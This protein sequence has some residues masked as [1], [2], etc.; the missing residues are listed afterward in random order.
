MTL[1]S[2]FIA[3]AV[4]HIISYVKPQQAKAPNVMGVLAF[5]F[6]N[7]IIA[8]L[9]WQNMDWAKWPALIFPSVGGLGLLG[10][11]IIQGK[12]TWIDYVILVL[13]IVVIGLVLS[14]FFI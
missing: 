5:V 7:A 12:G 1:I 14:Q 2:L 3:N 6:I 8:L 4:A 13:D 10:T 11:T 9:L